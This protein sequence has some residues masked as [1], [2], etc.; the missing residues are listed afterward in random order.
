MRRE[1]GPDR[2]AGLADDPGI[3][4]VEFGCEPLE[5]VPQRRQRILG[6]GIRP[7]Q[8]ALRG[9]GIEVLG[10]QRAA[11][12]GSPHHGLAPLDRR[13]R[14]VQP[15]RVRVADMLLQRR[16]HTATCGAG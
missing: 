3:V 14:M 9:K 16:A 10:R 15:G 12:G 7:D 8:M 2:A 13:D 6:D 4:I 1:D 5:F 11:P